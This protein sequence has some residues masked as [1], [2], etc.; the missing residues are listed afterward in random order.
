MS[1]LRRG[2]I[3]S[4]AGISFSDIF[5]MPHYAGS[6]S[7]INLVSGIDFSVGNALSIHKNRSASADWRFYDTLMGVNET[8]STS[9]SNGQTTIADTVKSFNNDGVT[10]GVASSS[11]NVNGNNFA[12]Y[13]LKDKDG[14]L[15]IK[16]F[17][18]ASASQTFNHDLNGTI[19][20]VIVTRTDAA[21]ESY[22]WHK[23]FA[24]DE[25]IS[26]SSNAAKQVSAANRWNNTLPT[27]TQITLGSDFPNGTYEVYVFGNDSG[28][29][30]VCDGYTGTGGSGNKQTTGFPVGLV[31]VK[32]SDD[33]GG[34]GIYD[35][36]RSPTNPVN[37]VLLPNTNQSEVVFLLGDFLSDGFDFAGANTNESGD[38]YIF[39]SIADP[40]QF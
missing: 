15:K 12:C 19:G 1:L 22:V 21:G 2:I 16:R 37:D 36:S 29:G 18:K 5:A 3:Q 7:D 34:W 26:M 11:V 10:I 28:E 14:F 33:I 25:F 17:V 24:A 31:L 8:I 40:A 32:K 38:T 20:M 6:V 9:Q 39:M 30:V 35:V 13:H 27:N 4:K 23:D